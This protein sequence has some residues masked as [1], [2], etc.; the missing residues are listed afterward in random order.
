MSDQGSGR[1]KAE[2]GK[3]SDLV[4][5]RGFAVMRRGSAGSADRNHEHTTIV[6]RCGTPLCTARRQRSLELVVRSAGT[7]GADIVVLGDDDARLR[8]ER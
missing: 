1:A 6:S 7:D 5:D 2:V 4:F 3:R 8:R